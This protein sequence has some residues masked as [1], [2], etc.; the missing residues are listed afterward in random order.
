MATEKTSLLHDQINN[1]I[2]EKKKFY[3][4]CCLDIP[5]KIEDK[6]IE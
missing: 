6:L 5:V 4:E 2:S 3:A 1:N